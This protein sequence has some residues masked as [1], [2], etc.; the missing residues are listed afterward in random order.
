ML[1]DDSDNDVYK[2]QDVELG[3]HILI[4]TV[5]CGLYAVFQFPPIAPLQSG[6]ELTVFSGSAGIGPCDHEPKNHY[7]LTSQP[8][9][10]TG[11][12]CV[13]ILTRPDD[14]VRSV[15]SFL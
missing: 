6:E 10:A 3:S 1:H 4:Q 9:W 15:T 7:F 8:R 5:E 14:K 13:T 12:N 11:P 2:S